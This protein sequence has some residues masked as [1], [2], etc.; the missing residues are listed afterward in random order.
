MQDT[1]PGTK[2]FEVAFLYLLFHWETV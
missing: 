2:L 1:L